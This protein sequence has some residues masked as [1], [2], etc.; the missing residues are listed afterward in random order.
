MSKKKQPSFIYKN[1][2]TLIHC[3]HDCKQS[4]KIA[5]LDLILRWLLKFTIAIGAIYKLD[6]QN[7]ISKLI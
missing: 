5:W 4:K 2:K 3:Y 6:F 1:G 7:I